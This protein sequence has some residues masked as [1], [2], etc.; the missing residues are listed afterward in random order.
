[1]SSSIFSI[2]DIGLMGFITAGIGG[3]ITGAFYNVT[4]VFAIILSVLVNLG[5]WAGEFIDDHWR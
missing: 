1:M 4:R 5:M 2:Q 3:F